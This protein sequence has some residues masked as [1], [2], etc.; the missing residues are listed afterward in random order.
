MKQIALCLAMVLGLCA[1]EAF[2][3]KI[4]LADTTWVLLYTT[5]KANAKDY[6]EYAKITFKRGGKAVFANG[7]TGRWTLKRN[8]LTVKDSTEEVHYVEVK[9]KGAREPEQQS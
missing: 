8:K 2:A 3:Q 5:G 9:I 7:E 6:Q 1:T 4:N